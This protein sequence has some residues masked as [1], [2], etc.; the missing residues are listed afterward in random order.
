MHAGP[1][2]HRGTAD[3]NPA[4]AHQQQWAAPDPID[5]RNGHERCRHIDRRKQCA[6]RAGHTEFRCRAGQFLQVRGRVV[7][8]GVDADELLHEKQPDADE[9]RPA[10]RQGKHRGYA[11][12]AGIA[13]RRIDLVNLLMR[14]VK[15]QPGPHRLCRLVIAHECQPHRRFHQQQGQPAQ[16]EARDRASAQKESPLGLVR[17]HR[18]ADVC[19]QD[20][21]RDHQLEDADQRAAAGNGRDLGDVQR[22]RDRYGPHADSDD[23]SSDQVHQFRRRDSA[24]EC[25]EGE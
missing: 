12:E 20:A 19:E 16:D 6:G 9:D 23:Q 8:H 14:A 17:E 7:D 10:T 5:Q 3:S 21:D 18:K 1:H 11:V 24:H 13:N 22:G 25:A 15:A 4:E 2:R